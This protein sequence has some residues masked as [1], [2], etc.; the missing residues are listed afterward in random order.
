MFIHLEANQIKL[1]MSIDNCYVDENGIVV[2]SA[3]NF[4]DLW[5]NKYFVQYLSLFNGKE[6]ILLIKNGEILKE[7]ERM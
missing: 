3:Y 1:H 2:I 6:C 4:F 5:I 7:K